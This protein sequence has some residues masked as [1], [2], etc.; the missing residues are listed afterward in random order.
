MSE[1]RAWAAR[2]K[3]PLT[4]CQSVQNLIKIVEDWLSKDRSAE[5]KSDSKTQGRRRASDIIAE[6]ERVIHESAAVVQDRD[7]TISERDFE[8][9]N[10]E[11]VIADLQRSLAE[12]EDDIV[13]LRDLLP[14]E[15]REQALDALTSAHELAADELAAIAERYHWR[16]KDPRHELENSTA[17]QISADA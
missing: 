13:A 10:R 3:H 6:Q 5:A 7:K 17:V 16:L 11:G 8:I 2:Q 15:A 14:A 1:A 12:C 9:A 4:E